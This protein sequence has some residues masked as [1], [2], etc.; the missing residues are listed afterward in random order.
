MRKKNTP[1]M[2]S[3]GDVAKSAS[4]SVCSPSSLLTARLDAAEIKRIKEV[5]VVLLEILKDEKLSVDQWREKEATRN[6]VEV[7]RWPPSVGH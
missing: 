3:L 6:A 1:R 2:P 4:H 7:V 5:S